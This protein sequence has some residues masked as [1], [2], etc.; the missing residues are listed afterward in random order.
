VVEGDKV[1]ITTG[2]R[3]LVVHFAETCIIPAAANSYRIKNLGS[4]TAKIVKAWLK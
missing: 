1:E 2:S 3:K 4:K